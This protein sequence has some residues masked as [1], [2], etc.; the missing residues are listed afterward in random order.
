MKILVAMDESG[1]SRKAL[2][3]AIRM[4]KHEGGALDIL[5][6]VPILGAVDEMTPRMTERF[7]RDARKVVDEA[8]AQA[9]KAGVKAKATV[10]QG[11]SPV[12]R[13]L[14]YIVDNRVELVVVGSRGRTDL[15]RFMLGSVA[16][17]LATYAPC[18]VYVVK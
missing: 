14:H 17:G 9:E 13:I 10:E 2:E 7:E 8:K 4:A 15:E 1:Y 5:T 12:D 3:A 6:V 18:S 16:A 11:A